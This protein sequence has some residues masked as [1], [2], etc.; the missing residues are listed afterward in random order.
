MFGHKCFLRIGKLSD[1]SI[2]GLYRDSY[3]LLNCDFGFLQGIDSNGKAQTEVKGGAISVTFPNI[4][5]NEMIEWMLKSNKL[6]NGAIVI[7]NSDDEP[8]E[9]I[10]FEDA[11]CIELNVNYNQKGK[12]FTTT[13]L[14]LQAKK[15][16]VGDN[17]L[18]NHWKNL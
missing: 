11:A 17:T 13:K 6:E 3:E 15:I 2:S 7:C 12:S 1:S 14:V 10:L 8:L 18:E 4:P 9:K 16:I 5:K